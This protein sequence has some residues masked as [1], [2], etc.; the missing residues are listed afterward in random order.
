MDTLVTAL[1]DRIG[2]VDLAGPRT[3][4]VTLLGVE[5]M[6]ASLLAVC[7]EYDAASSST[8]VSRL[9]LG[10]LLDKLVL[11]LSAD[12]LLWVRLPLSK[13]GRFLVPEE[14]ASSIGSL[15]GGEGP[16]DFAQVC[17]DGLLSKTESITSWTW[18]A[19][20]TSR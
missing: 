4:I 11:S 7:M 17:V 5:A 15:D 16:A 1:G 6:G 3:L 18:G 8:R 9:L 13:R 2:G 12:M 14:L 19:I 10:S 20:A